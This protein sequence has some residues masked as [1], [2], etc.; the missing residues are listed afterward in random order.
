MTNFIEQGYTNLLSFG[1]DDAMGQSPLGL[2]D[3]GGGIG[4]TFGESSGNTFGESSGDTT[5]ATSSDMLSNPTT[6]ET[7]TNVL[8]G[9]NLIDSIIMQKDTFVKSEG[10]IGFDDGEGYYFGWDKDLEK[11]VFFFGDSAGDK[12]TWDG[13]TFAIEGPIAATSGTIGGFEIGSDYIR[14]DANSFGLAS[15]VT[16][17][18]DVRFWAGDTFAN[19]ATAPLRLYESGDAVFQQ[20]TAS[21][22][23][24]PESIIVNGKL[25]A[26]QD[27]TAGFTLTQGEVV[28]IEA[29]GNIYPSRIT[30]SG[31][32]VD[33][34]ENLT[35]TGRTGSSVTVKIS[36]MVTLSTFIAGGA[37]IGQRVVYDAEMETITSVSSRMIITSTGSTTGS[38]APMSTTTCLLTSYASTTVYLQLL[39]DLDTTITS[40]TEIS[41]DTAALTP[42]IVKISDTKG[43]IVYK[44]SS[45]Q[46]FKLRIIT[47]SGTTVSVGTEQDLYTATATTLLMSLVRYE[48][49]D[50][51]AVLFNDD[52][53]SYIL[54]FEWDGV[55]LTAGTRVLVTSSAHGPGQ[56]CSITD[57]SLGLAHVIGQAVTAYSITRSGT[58]TTVNAGVT[59]ETTTSAT[60]GATAV[61]KLGS[62]SFAVYWTD[63]TS[64]T[65]NNNFICV[66]V[67]G[68][69]TSAIGIELGV[70]FESNTQPW[71]GSVLKVAPDLL[72]FSYEDTG[73]D[74]HYRLVK[75]DS[76]FSS[77]IGITAAAIT[78][79][80]VGGVVLTAFCDDVTGL[81]TATT[82]Y[83]GTDGELITTDGNRQIKV[84][85]ALSSTSIKITI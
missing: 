14:D 49:T 70:V 27:F 47:V 13:T 28:A 69:V 42:M 8:S 31:S 23:T 34:D 22:S 81:T 83:V 56:L 54:T 41:V 44:K 2:S 3:S 73:D 15:T 68:T 25:T 4:N 18:D 1:N 33:N 24:T 76:N 21:N 11:F 58:V 17:G 80:E 74:D 36:S 65:V 45:T 29:D 67:T 60:N 43:I 71:N 85:I 84:G 6:D 52:S 63:V 20:I 40:N 79:T 26:T 72:M 9:G 64:P 38:L 61:D 48:D 30:G 50:F 66:R 62:D 10:V 35:A 32:L 77:V 57:I 5:G 59:V 46:D 37:L 82:Y 7:E 12:V 39:S 16:G 78:A 75:L 53:N 55:N 51:Y 19:R